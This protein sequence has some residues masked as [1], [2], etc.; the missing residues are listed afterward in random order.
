VALLTFSRIHLF[1][2]F[3][4]GRYV[5]KSQAYSTPLPD[6]LKPLAVAIDEYEKRGNRT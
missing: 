6:Q 2:D 4:A 5:Q 3:D 1:A